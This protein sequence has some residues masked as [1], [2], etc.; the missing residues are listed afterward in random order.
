[1]LVIGVSVLVIYLSM[2]LKLPLTSPL[3][4]SS[5]MYGDMEYMDHS[6]FNS[7]VSYSKGTFGTESAGSTAS[8]QLDGNAYR[9]LLESIEGDHIEDLSDPP[10]NLDMFKT[11]LESLHGRLLL[12]EENVSHLRSEIQHKNTTI[13]QLFKIINK[14]SHC[15]NADTTY[16]ERVDVY[17]ENVSNYRKRVT[18]PM[19][20][21]RS[22]MSIFIIGA[23]LDWNIAFSF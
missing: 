6:V 12:M 10:S 14:Q 17:N 8:D 13:E 5:S 18:Y 15:T 16:N 7:S 19:F 1:M 9:T 4:S 22:E 3:M 2:V 21:I 11:L 20:Y 23:R